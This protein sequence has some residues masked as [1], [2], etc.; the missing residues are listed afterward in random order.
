M[1]LTKNQLYQ[2]PSE[3]HKDDHQT[4]E[5]LLHLRWPIWHHLVNPDLKELLSHHPHHES[6]PTMI[7]KLQ[8][9]LEF[10]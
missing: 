2:V 5:Y 7:T 4:S 10:T 1:G 8:H 3:E 9:R 6:I